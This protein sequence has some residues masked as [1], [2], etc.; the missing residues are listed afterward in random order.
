MKLQFV[1]VL[2]P[3]VFS[4]V[5]AACSPLPPSTNSMSTRTVQEVRG[6]NLIVSRVINAYQ[7][8]SSVPPASVTV[9]AY[10][11]VVQLDGYVNNQEQSMQAQQIAQ[12]IPGVIAVRNNLVVQ[13]PQ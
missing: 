4:L 6:D 8:Q 10:K 1:K 13:V 2:L 11:G 5:V 12:S 9:S 3:V 7:T